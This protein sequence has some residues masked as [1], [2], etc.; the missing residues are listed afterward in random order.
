M[1]ES[2][3]HTENG[4]MLNVFGDLSARIAACFRVRPSLLVRVA[5]APRCAVHALG[6]FLHL[7]PDADRTDAE[8]AAILD[9]SDPRELLRS[10]IPNAPK[11]LY[12]ALDRAG[13]HVRERSY[14]ER[15]G[16]LCVSPLGGHLL[17]DGPLDEARLGWAESLL[18]SDPAVL[19]L[20]SLLSRGIDI[21]A[22]NTIVAF[23]RAH[24]A[25][26][27]DDL[28]MPDGAGVPAVIHRLQIALNRIEAP[29]PAFS[30]AP[31]YRLIRSIGELGHTGKALNIRVR[32]GG[33][34]NWF[35]LAEGSTVFVVGDE[36]HFL[37]AVR[38]VGPTVCVI[39]EMTGPNNANVEEVT[40]A[41]LI[42]ALRAEG[43]R[44]LHYD[45][46]DAFSTLSHRFHITDSENPD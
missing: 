8:V 9:E 31:P 40:K 19:R 33:N 1:P 16:A 7:A 43:L 37:A 35:K 27:E 15:L 13:D 5:F 18:R 39:D 14:Y 29:S 41:K 3:Y 46:S 34:R 25:F 4:P 17:S 23:L 44:V 26:L 2:R 12:N 22:V 20:Q 36:P 24:D 28:Q 11:E 21:E 32:Y 38:C 10:A 30:L 6:A 42:D 45:P